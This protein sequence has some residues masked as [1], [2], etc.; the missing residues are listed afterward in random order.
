MIRT[1]YHTWFEFSGWLLCLVLW[2]FWLQGQIGWWQPLVLWVTF[3]VLFYLTKRLRFN[4][5]SIPFAAFLILFGWVFLARLNPTWATSQFW[6]ALIGCTAYLFGLWMGTVK[7]KYPLIWAI[8]ALG[9]ILGTAMFGQSV[10]GA[11]AWITVFGLRF[12]PVEL[13]RILL[14]FYLAHYF[15]EGRSRKELALIMATF[16]LGLAWQRDL[17]PALLVFLVFCWMS[18]HV[19]LTWSKLLGFGSTMAV[20]YV[21]AMY[22][23]PH[24]RSRTLAWLR[25]WD[26][27]NSEGYQVLQGLFALRSGGLVGQ[28]LGQGLA[29]VIPHMHTDYLFAII[30]EELGLLGTFSLLMVYLGLA[31]WSL[32]LLHNLEDDRLRMTGLGLTLLL[33][34][35]V[36]LVVGGILRL[37][38]FTGMTLPLVSYGSTSLVAQLWMLGILAGLDRGGGS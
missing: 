23:Y 36:F 38:P 1:L 20:G 37:V 13:A 10:G 35:Q 2:V 9:L 28:G 12:Q 17:G 5:G 26:H 27:L 34:V 18:L 4:A 14:V 8:G 15:S 25:P 32:R 30:G 22:W 24:L 7:L 11:R 31:F 29:H 3:M 19:E 33:H 6:G 16:F 21:G